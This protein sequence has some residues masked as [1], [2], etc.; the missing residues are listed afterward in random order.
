MSGVPCSCLSPLID[1]LTAAGPAR[2]VP[3][4]SEGEAVALA[5]GAWLAGLRPAI[6]F[7]NSGL[8]NA[9]N[10]LTSLAATYRIPMVL[11]IGWRG[12]PGAAD[13]PQHALMGQI[14]PDLLKLLQIPHHVVCGDGEAL[15][16]A[17]A[18]ARRQLDEGRS[19]AFLVPPGKA[20][21]AMPQ[22]RAPARRTTTRVRQVCAGPEP[23]RAEAIGTLVDLLPA[24]ALL[25]STTGKT[26]RELHQ[27]ADRAG[28]LYLVGSM[29][30]AAAVGLGLGLGLSGT[31]PVVILDGDGAALMHP[32]NFATIGAEAPGRFVHIVLDNGVHDS[33]GG[34]P[35]RSATADIARIAAASGYRQ[36]IR[37]GGLAGLARALPG[38]LACGG[39]ALLHLP[40]RPGSLARLGRPD[41]APPVLARRFR[42]EANRALHPQDQGATS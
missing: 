37:C 34:Q 5:A 36:A 1:R 9:V 4:T 24:D 35:T 39:P 28:N 17:V 23:T 11:L 14:T 30:Y 21:G 6:M 15:D 12:M 29:G 32:G 26:S 16:A 7:Q 42:A 19:F 40:I 41:L 38:A 10:P 27:I 8:G 22:D 3:A 2:H 31:R 13:E 20:D 25:L 33:T 18:H